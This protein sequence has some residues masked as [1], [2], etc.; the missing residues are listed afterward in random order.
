MTILPRPLA[1][2]H[3]PTVDLRYPTVDLRYGV[4]LIAIEGSPDLR[5][6]AERGL[7]VED[8]GALTWVP[9]VELLLVDDSVQAAVRTGAAMVERLQA[10]IEAAA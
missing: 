9:L 3:Q 7:I 10:A 8:T 6:P 1:A 2:I 5:K 4:A